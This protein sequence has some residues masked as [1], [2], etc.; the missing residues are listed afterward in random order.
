MKTSNFG[1]FVKH[2]IEINELAK[3]MTGF[4]ENNYKFI[5]HP[6]EKN[7]DYDDKSIICSSFNAG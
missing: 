5:K 3:H 2:L 7:N 6:T 1:K 4:T